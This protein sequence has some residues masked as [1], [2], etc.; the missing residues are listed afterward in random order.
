MVMLLTWQMLRTRF[1]TAWS[2]R[3][4]VQSRRVVAVRVVRVRAAADHEPVD[5][6]TTAGPTAITRRRSED[7]VNS[8]NGR[9]TPSRRSPS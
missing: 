1:S 6:R 3:S 8:Y 2:V 9:R 4:S 7:V 5:R